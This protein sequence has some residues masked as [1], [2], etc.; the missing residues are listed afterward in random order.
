MEQNTQKMSEVLVKLIDLAKRGKI[1]QSKEAE[2]TSI[3]ME[4]V[5][6]EKD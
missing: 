1:D 4:I 6:I 5:K 2:L 3:L